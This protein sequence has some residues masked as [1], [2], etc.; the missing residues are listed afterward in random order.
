M[1]ALVG[2]A[3]R[4]VSPDGASKGMPEKSEGAIPMAEKPP[5][6]LMSINDLATRLNVQVRHVRR[7]VAERRV[8]YIK[9]GHLIR[10]DPNDIERWLDTSRHP[11]AS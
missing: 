3:L 1:A 4:F 7:L 2:K 11:E 10:F 6:P 9:W 8:P 5:V